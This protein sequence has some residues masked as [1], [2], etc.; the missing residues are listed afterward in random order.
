VG[1]KRKRKRKMGPENR[2]KKRPNS[3]HLRGLGTA[4]KKKLRPDSRKKRWK[5]G[6]ETGTKGEKKET[7]LPSQGKSNAPRFG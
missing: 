5:K 6:G 3:S 4:G 1:V 7:V 2:G